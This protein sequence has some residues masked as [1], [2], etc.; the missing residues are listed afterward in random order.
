MTKT[1]KGYTVDHEHQTITLT[2]AFA[3]KSSNPSSKEFRELAAV[4]K[5]FPEYSM[6]M[7]TA[8]VRKDKET[9]GGLTVERIE[10]IIS[11]QENAEELRRE[12]DAFVDFWGSEVLDKKTGKMVIRAPYGKV[13]SW[14]L[15]KV[16]NGGIDEDIIPAITDGN[17]N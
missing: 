3:K 1:T 8:K 12:Y 5:H 14:Y 11:V 6:E 10:K 17:E 2:K 16:K 15:K 9:Y 13:K 4:H 7:R